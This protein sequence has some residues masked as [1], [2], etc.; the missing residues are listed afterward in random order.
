MITLIMSVVDV[1]TCINPF[2]PS[3]WCTDSEVEVS[4]LCSGC[5]SSFQKSDFAVVC[6]CCSLCVSPSDA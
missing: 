1:N 2:F 4:G 3:F 6:T 5:T